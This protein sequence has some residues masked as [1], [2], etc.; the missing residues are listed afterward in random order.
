MADAR[1]DPTLVQVT[2]AL[3]SE[4]PK[5]LRAVAANPDMDTGLL[6]AR[7]GPVDTTLRIAA[8]RSTL[9]GLLPESDPALPGKTVISFAI[10]A[11]ARET[12]DPLWALGTGT[13]VRACAAKPALL[14]FTHAVQ[15]ELVRRRDSA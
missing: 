4:A 9:G 6:F 12:E 3:Q 7:T 1:R 13:P 14:D 11:A 5:I 10:A 8:K 2:L 15:Q